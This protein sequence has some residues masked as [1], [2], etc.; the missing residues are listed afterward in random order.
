M[1][2]IRKKN[3]RLMDERRG[4]IHGLQQ[5]SESQEYAAEE[6][7]HAGSSARDE[8]GGGRRARTR[9]RTTRGSSSATEACS[10]RT[11]GRSRSTSRPSGRSS[12]RGRTRR[13]VAQEGRLS[14]TRVVGT[15]AVLA[16]SVAVAV[17]DTLVAPLLA[18]EEGQRL[19]VLGDVG[20]DAV[21]AD[22]AV[23]QRIG[24]AVVDLSGL[25]GDA[26]LL[27]ANE[28]ALSNVLV[29]PELSVGRG[30]AIRVD[31][32]GVVILSIL[33]SCGK[34]GKGSEAEGE[35]GVHFDGV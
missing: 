8:G 22:T 23:A 16:G 5:D 2:K 19:G 32:V 9:A 15:A 14:A 26:G 30:D 6:H 13:S 27:K 31:A 7:S 34:A 17:G 20:G 21:I 3:L 35:C 12:G 1:E 29:T 18:D 10:G 25:G 28:R 11:G 4:K 33:L 24:I